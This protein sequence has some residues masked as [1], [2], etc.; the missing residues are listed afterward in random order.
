[1][2]GLPNLDLGFRILVIASEI[3]VIDFCLSLVTM[4][5]VLSL[6]ILDME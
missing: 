4:I 6:C 2:I 5:F 3:L 1:M